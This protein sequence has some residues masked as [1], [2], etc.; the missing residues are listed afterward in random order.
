MATSLQ[1]RPTAARGIAGNTGASLAALG[2]LTALALVLRVLGM[3]QSLYGDEDFTYY[4]VSDRGLAGVWDAVYYTSI[5]PPLHYV[6]AWLSLQFGGDDT[7]LVR[8][9]SL[10]LGTALVPLVFLVAKRVGGARAG[11]LAALLIAVGP[12][13]IWYSNEARNYATLMFLIALSTLALLS[14]VEGRDRRWWGI[15]VLSACGALWCHY[16]AVFVVAAGGVWAIWAHRERLREVVVA[17]AAVAVGYLPWLPG[18]LEQRQNKLGIEVIDEFAPLTLRTVFEVPLQTLIGH[19]FYDLERFPGT[20]G[21]LFLL[22]LG[23]L[24]GA[25]AMRGRAAGPPRLAP[26]LRSERGL[27][28]ILALATPVGLLLY[29]VP[30]SSLYIPRNLSASLPALVVLVAVLVDLLLAAVPRRLAT[31]AAAALV[32][33]LGI[34]AVEF[35]GDDYRRPPYRE[36]ADY[37]DEVAPRDARVVEAPLALPPDKRLPSTTIDRY[38]E[39]EHPLHRYGVDDASAWRELRAGHDVYLVTPRRL[40]RSESVKSE[41]RGTEQAEAGLLR[42]LDQFG[43]PDGLAVLRADKRLDGIIPI[44]VLRYSGV[45]G[46]RLERRGRQEVISWSLAKR[47]SVSTGAAAGS[48]EELKPSDKGFLITG[49]ALDAARPRPADWVLVFSGSQLVAVSASGNRRPD[50]AKHHGASASLAGFAAALAAPSDVSAI[51]VFAVVDGQA[52]EL[53]L[54][55]TAKRSAR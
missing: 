43:G 34:N 23:G 20:V 10:L 11:L 30:G 28:L 33:V 26:M 40:L 1:Q 50:I 55:E 53:P 44:S 7:I 6:L 29:A 17:H 14:A 37:I 3:D 22:I 39:R 13:A 45:V 2:V 25:A 54:S 16:T 32:A 42:R 35:F 47:V 51:R 38:F 46:G 9:P 19:P 41:L 31:I 48:V 21:L 12:Y 24:A 36:A 49:W 52:S 18:F 27:A 5:T 15:Y 4:I 8:L